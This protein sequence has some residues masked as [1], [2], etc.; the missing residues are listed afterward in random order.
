MSHNP[1]PENSKLGRRIIWGAVIVALG[2]LNYWYLN[3]YLSSNAGYITAFQVPDDEL[4]QYRN[5]AVAGVFYSA[6]P[7][8]LSEQVDK[9]VQSGRFVGYAAYQPK[10]VIVPHAGYMYSA[11]TAG[12]AY[13]VLQKYAPTIKKVI[14]LGPSHYEGARGAFLSDADYFATPLGSLKV[15]KDIESELVKSSP[16]FKFN[17]KPHNKE[18]SIEVQ[19]PFLKKV[20]PEAQIVPILYGNIAPEDLAKALQKYLASPDTVLLVSADLSHYNDYETAQKQDL[21]TADKIAKG[22]KLENHDSCGAI[23]INTALLLAKDNH[24][25][26]QLLELINSGDTGG[27]KDRVV[28]YGAWSFYP[29]SSPAPQPSRLE[30]QVE[31]L[32]AYKSLYSENLLEIAKSSVEKAV[33]H[34]GAYS[35]SRRHYPEQLF[36]KGA[37]FV[38]IYKNGELRGCIGSVL[39]R[40]AIALDIAAN[41]RAAAL[42]DSRFSPITVE[43]LPHLSYEVSLL[44]GFEK[45][46]YTNEAEV[47]RKIKQ[48]IDG[49]VIRDGNRQG[50]FLPSV[51]KQ[52][53]HKEEFFKQLKIKA[54]MNPNYW[55]NRINVYRFRTVEIKNED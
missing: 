4:A 17:N 48:G 23:G 2:I 27:D 21:A 46:S 6:R 8:E 32:K 33:R 41:A 7:E 40:T 22:D 34:G 39:P 54:G 5:P 38:T 42:E 35:P 15:H 45:I 49:I 14:V 25:R 52:L 47:L 9:Y 24:Y 50:V 1:N 30:R 36:D 13:A 37:A 44:S 3:K 53:P 10:I 55:N 18:H 11:S 26:P 16:L 28:G 43:E 20:L 51:W 19:L 31:S 29:D 12:K